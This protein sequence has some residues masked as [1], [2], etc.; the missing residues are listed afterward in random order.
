M[1]EDKWLLV[2]AVVAVPAAVY[3]I[4]RISS[5]SADID[6]RLDEVRADEETKPA[7]PHRALFELWESSAPKRKE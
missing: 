4:R 6:R 5:L 7:D 1:L 3:L 2:L